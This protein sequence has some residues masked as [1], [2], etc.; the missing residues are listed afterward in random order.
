LRKSDEEDQRS[1]PGQSSP[2]LQDLISDEF[3][4]E[5]DQTL[6]P[7][8]VRRADWYDAS[9]ASSI[10][11]YSMSRGFQSGPPATPSDCSEDKTE[12]NTAEFGLV[13]QPVNIKVNE[14]PETGGI[15]HP[16]V[17]H[18]ETSSSIVDKFLGRKSKV[19]A[20]ERRGL[21]SSF[22][23]LRRVQSVI[24][25]NTPTNAFP[26]GQGDQEEYILSVSLTKSNRTSLTRQFYVELWDRLEVAKLAYVS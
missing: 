7:P 8:E 11:S 14:K 18:S 1:E 26:R 19:R 17:S 2:F 15:I 10:D 23:S 3:F 12:V 4:D 13:R 6:H 20:K 22:D 21:T 16:P 5:E 24:G 25:A 9:T